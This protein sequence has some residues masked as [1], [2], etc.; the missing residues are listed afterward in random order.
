[1][2]VVSVTFKVVTNTLYLDGSALRTIGTKT[3]SLTSCWVPYSRGFPNV[4]IIQIME[5]IDS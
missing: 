5:S 3:T 4:K 2:G 1:M